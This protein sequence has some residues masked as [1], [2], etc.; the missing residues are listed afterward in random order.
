MKDPDIFASSVRREINGKDFGFFASFAT[1]GYNLETTFEEI[2]KKD[3]E[4]SLSY[5]KS[6][7]DKYFRTL[8]VMAIADNCAKNAKPAPKVKTKP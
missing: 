1:P 4:L 8:A 6:L 5:A 7:D 3:F 2:S